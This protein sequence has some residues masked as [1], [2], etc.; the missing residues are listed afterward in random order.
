VDGPDQL[1]NPQKV[2]VLGFGPWS[3]LGWARMI[4]LQLHRVER[5]QHEVVRA[6][7]IQPTAEDPWPLQS[8][9]AVVRADAH[10]LMVA[11][12]GLLRVAERY[13]RLTGDARVQGAEEKF[14]AVAPGAKEMRNVL[15]HAERYAVGDGNLQKDRKLPQNVRHPELRL[16]SA[17]PGG[18]G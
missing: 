16:R 3:P 1:S 15:E 12:G 2:M 9:L 17:A 10:F 5:G 4:A 7:G 14:E 8:A 6:A 18:R 11:I 13:R